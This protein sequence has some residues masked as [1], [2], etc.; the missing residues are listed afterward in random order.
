MD[1]QR[2]DWRGMALVSTYPCAMRHCRHGT[3][4]VVDAKIDGLA[5]E[6]GE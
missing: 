1:R 3:G 4:V 5:C 2:L 6:S